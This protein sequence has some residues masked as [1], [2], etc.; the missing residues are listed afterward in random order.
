METSHE[1]LLKAAESG[2]SAALLSALCSGA[3][4]ESKNESGC[5]VTMWAARLGQADCLSLLIEAGAD[6][7]AKKLNGL[8]AAMLAANYGHEDCVLMIEAERERRA[9]LG[10]VSPPAKQKSGLRI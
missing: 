8:T 3:D 9:L 2:G 7:H 4:I 1:L 6:I 5:P 10:V